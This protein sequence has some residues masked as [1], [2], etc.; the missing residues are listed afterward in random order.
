MT[1]T[2]L[3]DRPE[4]CPSVNNG[5]NYRRSF[6]ILG[7]IILAIGWYF[8]I[9]VYG[10]LVDPYN[11]LEN[12]EFLSSEVSFDLIP[13]LPD[14]LAE[15]YDLLNAGQEEKLV[16]YGWVDEENGIARI[17]I[18]EAISALLVEGFPVGPNAAAEEESA[19]AGVAESEG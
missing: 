11:K 16:G 3:P 4:P 8:A 2:N 19:D 12:G 15:S 1:N 18:D 17:S 9:H 10:T 6:L 13:V 7:I 5:H 14:T